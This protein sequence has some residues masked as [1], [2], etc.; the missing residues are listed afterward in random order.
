VKYAN[1][2]FCGEE[3]FNDLKP[4]LGKESLNK[5]ETIFKSKQ[6]QSR[7]GDNTTFQL[8]LKE[9][10]EDECPIQAPKKVKSKNDLIKWLCR[11]PFENSMFFDIDED[12]LMRIDWN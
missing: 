6:V 2:Y 11:T 7:I 10:V 12:C 4:Y 8:I 3:K 1:L 9:T 5:M